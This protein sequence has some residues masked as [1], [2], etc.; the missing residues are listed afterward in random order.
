MARGGSSDP[1]QRQRYC[2]FFTARYRSLPPRRPAGFSCMARPLRRRRRGHFDCVGRDYGAIRTRRSS[3]S[4]RRRWRSCALSPPGDKLTLSD[5]VGN[6]PDGN[7]AL[8]QRPLQDS[9][10]ERLQLDGPNKRIA[11]LEAGNAALE[12]QIADAG[13]IGMGKKAAAAT[14]S[15][16]IAHAEG[17]KAISV[18]P[19]ICKVGNAM[20]AFNSHATLDNNVKA[21]G[22]AV[23]RIGDVI[24]VVQGDAG[25]HIVSGTS[26][27][28]G[29]VKILD[30][31]DKIKVN[32]QAIAR[33]DSRCLVNCD[34]SGNGGAQGKV[35]TEVKSTI[36]LPPPVQPE[37]KD[38]EQK[39]RTSER[40]EAL[41]RARTDVAAHM[42]NMNAPDEYVRFHDLD[43]KLNGWIQQVSGKG[44]TAADAIAQVTRGFL[45]FGKD[46]AIGLG[47]IAYEGG[48]GVFKL[49]QLNPTENGNLIKQIDSQILAE[50][51]R[52]GNV[53]WARMGNGV[54]ALGSAIVKP[55]TD[56]W[57]KEQYGEAVT[58]AGMEIGTLGLGLTKSLRLGKGAVVDTAMSLSGGSGVHVAPLLKPQFSGRWS[59]YV[60]HGIKQNPLRSP[61]G[62]R[63]VI[64]FE[65]Q[66]L[67]RLQ[68]VNK[69]SKLMKTGSTLP[70]ANPIE[71]NDKFYKVIT[72][73]GRVGAES[74]FWAKE[75]DIAALKGLS[76]D[77]IASRLGLP[78][79]SQQGVRFQVVEIRALRP[80]TSF[81][82]VI[83]PTSEIGADGRVWSQVGGEMQTLLIDRSPFTS[84]ALTTITFP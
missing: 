63:L 14:N 51:I 15:C 76:A 69:A 31:H 80:S 68:A 33:H 47:E 50:N 22:T 26:L 82:S 35:I 13:R 61:E 21:R 59:D 2:Y 66:G 44:G 20:V 18:A 12:K 8:G 37:G 43:E 81:T 25:K 4:R 49:V 71:V 83:A 79:V 16:H 42:A 40:L 19:D 57:K 39:D 28:S 34:A 55:V 3:P 62:K 53:G 74:A 36:V 1:R 77:E 32:G 41:K 64:E 60:T 48:K 9:I 73:G 56:P 23:Y 5:P 58:R 72:E 54:I 30:G 46:L 38:K 84:P 17:W 10:A 67:S 65:K 29:H 70:H 75:A 6:R 52:L 7:L 45:G 24:K 11:Q 27:G 78:L